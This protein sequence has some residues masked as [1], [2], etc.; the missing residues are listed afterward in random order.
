M[1]CCFNKG[2]PECD[3]NTI[4]IPP[5]SKTFITGFAASYYAPYPL[6]LK[7]YISEEKFKLEMEKINDMTVTYFP[8]SMCF[9]YGY[10]LAICTLGLSFLCPNI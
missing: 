1:D 7:D 2:I 8:C 3:E 9:G 5:A 10:A 4:I 6:I